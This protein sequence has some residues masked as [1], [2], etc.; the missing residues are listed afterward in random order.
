MKLPDIY[1]AQISSA[2][3]LKFNKLH[4]SLNDCEEIVKF[5]INENKD[6]IDEYYNNKPEGL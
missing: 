1:I 4:L 6:L 5:I 3:Y 2:I